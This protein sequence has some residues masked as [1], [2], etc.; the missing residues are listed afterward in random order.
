[1]VPLS[2]AFSFIFWREEINK[3]SVFEFEMPSSVHIKFEEVKGACSDL[4]P[5]FW[6]I[7]SWFSSK[8]SPGYVF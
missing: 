3:M 1:M 2:L 6:E 8:I 7:F 4:P 5:K